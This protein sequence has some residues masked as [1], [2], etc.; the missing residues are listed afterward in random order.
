MRSRKFDESAWECEQTVCRFFNCL[1]EG[2]FEELVSLMTEDGT[3]IRMGVELK[4]RAEILKAMTERSQTVQTRHLISNFEFDKTGD[5]EARS[6]CCVTVYR[7]EGKA[8]GQT[9]VPSLF[10]FRDR[11]RMVD[12]NWNIDHHTGNRAMIA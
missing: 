12:G 3:W 7:I 6:K 4:G 8:K 11:L 1:D 2:R 5:L 10:V 9:P